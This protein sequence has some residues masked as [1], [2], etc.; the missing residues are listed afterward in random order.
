MNLNSKTTQQAVMVITGKQLEAPNPQADQKV[1]F[2][3][4]RLGQASKGATYF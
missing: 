2:R 3:L 4:H 1:C